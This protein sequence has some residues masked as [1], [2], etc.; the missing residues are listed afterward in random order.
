[1]SYKNL[2]LTVADRVARLELNRPDKINALSME[3]LTELQDALKAVALMKDEARVLVVSGTGRGFSAGLDLTAPHPNPQDREAPMRDYFLPAYRLLKDFPVPTVAAV[4]GPV[5]GAG[6]SLALSCDIVVSA[7]TAY[8]LAAFVN[9]G[10]VPDTGASWFSPH[11]LGTARAMG[12]LMLGEKLP[13]E[14]AEDWGLIWKCVDDDKLGGEVDAIASR[15]ANGASLAYG[16][17]KR[18]VMQNAHGSYHDA[19]NREAEY[20][21]LVRNSED[22]IEAR[23]A[24]AEKRPPVF[25]GR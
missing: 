13:A 9:I 11:S 16:L 2:T 25:K 14:K 18:M 15:L 12:M 24:F 21:R 23:K 17:I 3:T 8:F 20:Q 7:R 10:L 22:A 5:V 1:M 19:L 6:M 4:H